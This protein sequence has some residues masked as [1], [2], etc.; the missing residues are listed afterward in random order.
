MTPHTAPLRRDGTTFPPV[1]PDPPAPPGCVDPF[2]DA[3]AAGGTD[4]HRGAEEG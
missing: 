2:A 4:A 1:P 3:P